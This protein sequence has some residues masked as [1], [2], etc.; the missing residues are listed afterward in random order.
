MPA[1]VCATPLE[2]EG[3]MG[4]G[5]EPLAA[6]VLERVRIDTMQVSS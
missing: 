2:E 1:V 6:A 4:M 5:P 3:M